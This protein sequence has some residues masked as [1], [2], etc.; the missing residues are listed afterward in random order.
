MHAIIPA[1]G[2]GTRMRPMTW[3]TPKPLLDVAGNTILGHI[4]DSL[5][6]AGIDHVT[7]IVGYLGELVVE[8]A[9]KNYPSVSVDYFIQE[10]MDGL[11]S[12]VALAEPATGDGPTLV[13]LGDTLIEGDFTRFLRGDAN[14]LAV[15]QVDDPSG[16]GVVVMK[17]GKVEKLVEKPAE[18]L[19]DMAI[20]GV[21]GFA[22]GLKLMK[23]VRM[24]VES[25][26]KT[27]GEFQL[28]DAMQ[29]MLDQGEEFKVVEVDAWYDCGKPE[30]LLAT[31]RA[32]LE[33]RAGAGNHELLDSLIIEPVSI[34]PEA[35]VTASV[36]GPYVSLARGS[37]LKRS[38]VSNSIVGRNTVLSHV[39]L[40][41][42]II[43]ADAKL[44]GRPS[45]L[46][47]GDDCKVEC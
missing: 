33:K 20:V 13:V 12:A 21:Y 47:L 15:S 17:D 4:M 2:K 34:H 30:T 28:T 41:D 32:L 23:A 39:V 11:A 45:G 27:G 38:V 14:V 37:K 25:G 3:S 35:E 31:N 24:L 44:T 36:I 8:W 1:A 43:G 9:R 18:F 46:I 22:S 40:T 7:L 42:S 19:S 5:V 26:R 6:E 16:F 29:L 10:K